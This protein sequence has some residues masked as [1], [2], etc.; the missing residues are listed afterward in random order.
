MR[1]CRL[2]MENFGAYRDRVEID[3]TSLASMFLVC[4]KTGSG[5]TTIFDALTYALYGKA[6]GARG[7]L[8]AQL[9]SQHAAPGEAPLVEFE[10]RLGA[11]LY[12]AVRQ[13][14]YRRLK[15]G[16]DIREVPAEAALYRLDP[17]PESGDC[18][19]LIP[20][21]SGDLR[22]VTLIAKGSRDVGEEMN[23]RI[24]LTA[25][26]FSKIILL[27][28]GEFQRFLEMDSTER[29]KVLEKLFPVELH[30]KTTAITAERY[31]AAKRELELQESGLKR[32]EEAAGDQPEAR[33]AAL[34]SELEKASSERK[35]AFDLA[36]SAR[37]AF[38]LGK[39]EA[40]RA[41]REA[42][43]RAALAE[44]ESRI[45]EMA[46]LS[47]RLDR[48]R[49]A[50]L[51][52]PALETHE[53]A[54]TREDQEQSRVRLLEAEHA[55][56]ESSAGQAEA[57]DE[58]IRSMETEAREL[59]TR[60][61]KLEAA[62]VAWKQVLTSGKEKEKALRE[63][64]AAE[65]KVA[66]LA[67]RR[68]DL[69]T[70]IQAAAI[71]PGEEESGRARADSCRHTLESIRT[72][73][74]AFRR[75]SD[76]SGS[77]TAASKSVEEARTQALS[78]ASAARTAAASLEAADARI[79]ANRAAAMA[80]DLA[81]GSPCPVC[82]SKSHPEPAHAGAAPPSSAE[83]ERL[84]KAAR[85][86]MEKESQGSANLKAS[87]AIVCERREALRSAADS[88]LAILPSDYEEARE[89]LASWTFT[90][91]TQGEDCALPVV[92]PAAGP[93]VLPADQSAALP[94]ALQAPLPAVVPAALADRLDEDRLLAEKAL[95]AAT[96]SLAELDSRRST[97]E[98]L[99]R[100]LESLRS[101]ETGTAAALAHAGSVLASCDAALRQASE[102]AGGED[103]GPA[104]ALTRKRS[105]ELRE[106]LAADKDRLERWHRRRA[107]LV[108]NLAETRRRLAEAREESRT[109]AGAAGLALAEQHFSTREELRAS[110]LPESAAK[111]LEKTTRTH[112]KE[113]AEARASLRALRP[114]SSL[115]A[116]DGV[117]GCTI[118]VGDTSSADGIS[119][120]DEEP[121]PLPD[122]AALET[123]WRDAQALHEERTATISRLGTDRE[124]LSRTLGDLEACRK[125]AAHAR[126]QATG[127]ASLASLLSGTLSGR[128][129]PFKNFALSW[130]FRAVV[131]NASR[132]LAE[133]SDGRYSLVAE[134]GSAH[135]QG[136]IG[137]EISVRDAYT[138][139]TRPAGTL[140]GGERFLTSISLAF[141]LSDTIVSRSG[142][143]SLDSVFIDE[144]F[145]SLDEE[146]LDRAI[147]VLD[148]MRGDRIIGIVS[149]VAELRSRIP[150]RILVEKGRSGSSLT[151]VAG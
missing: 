150:S 42:E 39:K 84:A 73:V 64:A 125:E 10:F 89:T 46:G 14:P 98:R 16:G 117:P 72:S 123:A 15:K 99:R 19:D 82:G 51:A 60:H 40:E 26:E 38:E 96:A 44:L 97:L 108:R 23:R 12:R 88:F 126:T 147:T 104:L 127:L 3:F 18:P 28:Q 37:T 140:S 21:P 69:E 109:T 139:R 148:R 56:H 128:R 24:G 67:G 9:W 77:L 91:R 105:L 52:L 102:S 143:V 79:A 113:L 71:P 8:E 106:R 20:S 74:E 70:K 49:R 90:P 149:H 41:R 30:E 119:K 11:E 75:L 146:A 135:S 118:K 32:L 65:A 107:E 76:S 120:A 35:Q 86:A 61:G 4:G 53:R 100:E 136:K 87:L 94:E 2:V 5:K 50:A 27:P 66:G 34:D 33:L 48:A 83:R 103:P 43:A 85:L 131:R 144:G 62:E 101:E 122:L 111:A 115:P 116:P 78:L 25:D 81:E 92:L 112:D 134:E 45:P 36:S 137:L 7:G 93:E 141:G 59:D 13:P 68:L 58:A 47:E 110:M 145:G 57:L 31:K 114:E 80:A 138:G 22:T 121:A 54:R 132:R 133:M 129:L 1:P 17:S 29:V 95:Q 63:V 6:P 151:I 130:H 55:E 124:R 142:G